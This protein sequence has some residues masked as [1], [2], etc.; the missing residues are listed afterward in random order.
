LDELPKDD[1]TAMERVGE[2]RP[3]LLNNIAVNHQSLGNYS[4]AE[5][6]YG[7]AIQETENSKQ[8]EKNLKLTM[9]YNLARLYE[10]KLETAKATA[11]YRKIIEDYPA[12]TDGNIYI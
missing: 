6:Y 7:L 10:E 1:P 5:H 9:S 11:I 2:I 8:D 4:D 3:G 12:Y